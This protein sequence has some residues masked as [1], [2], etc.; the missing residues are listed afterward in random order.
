MFQRIFVPELHILSSHMQTFC[1][2]TQVP[3]AAIQGLVPPAAPVHPAECWAHLQDQWDVHQCHQAVLVCGP[4]QKWSLLCAWGLR[5][6]TLH[7]SHSAVPL[8]DT[9]Q[10]ANW[11]NPIGCWSSWYF[12]STDSNIKTMEISSHNT[13]IH[14]DIDAD[15]A[16]T[17]DG[18][19][20][21]FLCNQ[22]FCF[23]STFPLLT[24]YYSV[25]G[26]SKL[27][28]RDH[29]LCLPWILNVDS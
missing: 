29:L 16:D 28:L 17:N 23:S 13:T 3:R 6:L 21:W 14:S 22:G 27:L 11:G 26:G 1:H 24:V 4:V 9:S 25:W 8:Q 10:D 2:F 20:M 12:S 5:T 7:F 15:G 18:W 19:E